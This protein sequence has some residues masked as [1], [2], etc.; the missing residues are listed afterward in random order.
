MTGR[1]REKGAESQKQR[2]C[3]IGSAVALPHIKLLLFFTAF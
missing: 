2:S 3:S 1:P